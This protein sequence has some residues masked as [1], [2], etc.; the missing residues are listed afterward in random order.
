MRDAAAHIEDQGPDKE[1]AP[2]VHR[3]LG[4]RE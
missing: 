3:S 4:L 2:I 1:F